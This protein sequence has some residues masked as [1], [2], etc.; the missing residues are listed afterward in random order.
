MCSS[1]NA[2]SN[3][4]GPVFIEMLLF[5]YYGSFYIFVCYLFIVPKCCRSL[6]PVCIFFFLF[7][8]SKNVFQRADVYNFDGVQFIHYFF[9]DLCFFCHIS[10][11][12]CVIKIL[13]LLISFLL[14]YLGL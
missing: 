6:L 11:P 9:Y 4:N 14:L 2:F 13:V 1:V 12:A 7:L 8:V 3:Y 10:F 5:N